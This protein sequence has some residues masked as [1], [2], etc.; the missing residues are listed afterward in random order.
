MQSYSKSASTVR[1]NAD[2]TISRATA[3]V[4]LVN[5]P[6]KFVAANGFC[7]VVDKIKQIKPFLMIVHGRDAPTVQEHLA[8]AEAAAIAQADGIPVP[9]APIATVTPAPQAELGDVPV[10]TVKRRTGRL[11]QH[12]PF[13]KTRTTFQGH[14]LKVVSASLA[15]GLM[16]R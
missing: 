5:I 11:F 6:E 9:S 3:I 8:A 1:P 12:D 4:E 7:Y 2:Y 14:G 16:S 13:L 15:I 10:S